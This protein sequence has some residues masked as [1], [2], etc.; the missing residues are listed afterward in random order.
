MKT[1]PIN[2]IGLETRRCVVVG[3]GAVATRKLAGLLAAGARVTVISLELSTELESRAAEKQIT[4]LRRAY[5]PG[6]L[7]GAFLVI[8]ATDDPPTNAAVW[9]EARQLGCLINAVDDP[10]HSNFILP[11][12]VRRGEVNLAISTG[13]ASPTLARRLREQL[14]TQVGPE[15]GDLAGLMAELRP[16]IML[17]LPPGEA[18]QAAAQR[19]LDSD[20]LEVVRRDGIEAARRRARE[21]LG[22]AP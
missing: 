14:E 15:Y 3:G 1:Y 21:L 19:L 16:E 17:Q 4:V 7:S 18:R 8:A 6:D 5:E 22:L 12:V 20:L 9:D 2:L 13:G 11:A 10:A